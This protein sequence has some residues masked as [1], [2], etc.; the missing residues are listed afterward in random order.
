MTNAA[1]AEL[2]TQVEELPLFQIIVLRQKLDRILERKKSATNV[3]AGLALLDEFAGS[4][5]R[6]IDYKKEREEKCKVLPFSINNCHKIYL[7]Q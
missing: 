7:F 1:F 6:E 2:E 3:A 5:E 4:V